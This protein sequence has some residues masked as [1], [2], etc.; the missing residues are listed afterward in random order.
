MEKKVP[1]SPH[2]APPPPA[3]AYVYDATDENMFECYL[4]FVWEDFIA[5][6]QQK[7]E[8]NN[9]KKIIECTRNI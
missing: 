9:I 8:N 3:G 1:T 2:L 7:A 4:F 6:D 5:K